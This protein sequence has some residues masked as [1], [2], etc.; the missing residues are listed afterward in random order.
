MISLGFV[1]LYRL[2]RRREKR[3]FTRAGYRVVGYA[4]DNTI[5]IRRRSS[6]LG[7]LRRPSAN[8]SV[9][10][11]DDILELNA[12]AGDIGAMGRVPCFPLRSDATIR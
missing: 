8:K 5:T 3:W 4:A 1:L 6:M 7:P 2:Q 10:W 11:A 9:R 12:D